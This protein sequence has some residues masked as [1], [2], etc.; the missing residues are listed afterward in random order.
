MGET[1]VYDAVKDAIIQGGYMV[2]G[3]PLHFTS[4][5][6]AGVT[7]TFV[8][9]PVDVIKTR[10]AKSPKETK[11]IVNIIDFLYLFINCCQ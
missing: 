4:A 7:A 8:A 2:E 5:V 6:V 9:S 10:S 3:I 1:V 11:S